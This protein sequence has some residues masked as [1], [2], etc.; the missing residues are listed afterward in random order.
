M[1]CTRSSLSRASRTSANANNENDGVTQPSWAL[2]NRCGRIK[3]MTR[4]VPLLLMSFMV[5]VLPLF[6]R[7]VGIYRRLHGNPPIDV[8]TLE[9]PRGLD[10]K[11]RQLPAYRQAVD[12]A[13]IDAR[14]AA[15]SQTV[16]TPSSGVLINVSKCLRRQN[17]V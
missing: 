7:L 4:S 13:L 1:S 15:T 8:G 16:K 9:S 5:L 2:G 11:A 6:A 12:R 10:L 3:S 17:G 14:V